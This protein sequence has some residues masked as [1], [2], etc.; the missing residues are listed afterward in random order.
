M[1]NALIYQSSEYD[2]GPT[3]LLNAVRFLF[4]REEVPPF[5]LRQIWLMGNDTCCEKGGPGLRGTS[6]AS[7]RYMAEWLR[8]YGKNCHFPVDAL[9]LENEQAQVLPGGE[10]WHWL[11][12]GGCAVMRCFAGGIPHFVLLTALLPDGEIG[13][14][15]PYE[16]EPD[17]QG[18][19]RR[20]VRDQPRRMNR[21]VDYRLV[22]LFAHE[23]YA[24]GKPEERELLLIRRTAP[25]GKGE[26]P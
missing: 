17:F 4:E 18:S 5:I 3:C 10:A 22:N 13:L 23:D 20:I 21:A 26:N 16:E 7:M 15:D 8:E 2:C 11:E 6:R 24:M 19:G 14:F 1:K 9:F 25:F 12:A